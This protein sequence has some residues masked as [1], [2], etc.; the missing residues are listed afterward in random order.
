M[1]K[2]VGSISYSNRAQRRPYQSLYVQNA[3]KTS[4][5]KQSKKQKKQTDG[6]AR[7]IKK[8]LSL[9]R[10][11]PGMYNPHGMRTHNSPGGRGIML[12]ENAEN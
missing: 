12:C 2:E 4:N 8:R 10:R 7:K 5:N 3:D 1:P 9:P 6:G 11:N